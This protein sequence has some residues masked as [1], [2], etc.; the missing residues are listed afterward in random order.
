MTSGLWF[1]GEV[2]ED[3][4][5]QSYS[6][7]W[8]LSSIIVTFNFL[9]WCHT[10]AHDDGLPWWVVR[11]RHSSLE[12]LM[13]FM[14]RL[15]SLPCPWPVQVPM[16]SITVPGKGCF[17]LS[18]LLGWRSMKWYE[19]I[20]NDMKWSEMIW[21]DMTWHEMIWYDMKL[22]DMKW[23]VVH[24]ARKLVT[25]GISSIPGPHQGADV[26]QL[27]PLEATVEDAET[28]LCQNLEGFLV[29]NQRN[30]RPKSWLFLFYN[31][32]FMDDYQLQGPGTV[33]VQHDM[34]TSIKT[35]TSVSVYCNWLELD[36]DF[37]GA[38]V[39][40]MA[41]ASCPKGL[42]I[43]KPP[44]HCSRSP[45][46]CRA[47]PASWPTSRCCGRL[48]MWCASSERR[49]VASASRPFFV[50]SKRQTAKL[51]NPPNRHLVWCSVSL[52]CSSVASAAG[53]RARSCWPLVRNI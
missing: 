19:T 25:F 8:K 26:A 35:I 2:D 38:Q 42:G 32:F 49:T 29:S 31:R 28:Q 50:S 33:T 39:H 3:V 43:W 52:R 48:G 41:I 23:N 4:W 51:P 36:I 24:V 46:S 1:R 15:W 5:D 18:L 6:M 17:Q 27:R 22:Y 16:V 11:H 40:G 7:S 53:L 45:S 30:Q 20:W 10:H 21:N 37:A 44:R 9:W 14:R 13:D 34:I 47:R 12:N